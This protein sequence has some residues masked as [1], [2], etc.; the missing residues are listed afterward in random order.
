MTVRK[1]RIQEYPTAL[2]LAW[3]G[4]QR[5]EAPEYPAQGVAHFQKTLQDHSFTDQLQIYG[6]FDGQHLAGM[7]A[8]RKEGQHIALFFVEEAYHRRGI[9]RA[10]FLA[11][12]KD[13]PGNQMTV[14]ASPFA[15]PVYQKL[16]FIATDT[17]QL[18]DGIRYT[19]MVYRL[20]QA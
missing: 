13:M 11:A 5:F 7:L 18:T 3:A 12:L 14:N 2:A 1:L 15:V 6:A 19:P 16:G 9:G 20:V 17:E 8:T 4:F 10:L